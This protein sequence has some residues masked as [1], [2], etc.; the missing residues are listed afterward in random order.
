MTRSSDREGRW[1]SLWGFRGYSTE[2]STT[3]GPAA[4]AVRRRRAVKQ[5]SRSFHKARGRDASLFGRLARFQPPRRAWDCAMAEARDRR[6]ESPPAA[7]EAPSP[8][9][10]PRLR[11]VDSDVSESA[12]EATADARRAATEL[13]EAVADARQDGIAELAAEI[14]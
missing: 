9:A 11:A 1:R 14:R 7:A 8:A 3:S 6:G 5:T 4:R 13:A 10:K 2:K 12:V